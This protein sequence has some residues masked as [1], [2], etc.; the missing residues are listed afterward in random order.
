MIIY[1]LYLLAILMIVNFAIGAI[2]GIWTEGYKKEKFFKGL[3]MYALIFLGFAALGLFAHF[4][5]QKATGFSY[6][7][8]VL[9]DPIARY[10]VRLLDTLRELL[11]WVFSKKPEEPKRITGPVAEAVVNQSKQ[12]S[13]LVGEDGMPVKRKRGRPRKNPLPDSQNVIVN[14]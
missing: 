2:R 3:T 8:G 12:V 6:L 5:G 14:K 4:A 10:L 11:D 7:A 1:M 13:V 9:I